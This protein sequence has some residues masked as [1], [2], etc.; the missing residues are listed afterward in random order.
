MW[1]EPLPTVTKSASHLRSWTILALIRGWIFHDRGPDQFHDQLG[2]PSRTGFGQG[3]HR[4]RSGRRMSRM[5]TDDT[6]ND[7]SVT[8][9]A[10]GAVSTEMS[11][12]ATL[13]PANRVT[14][15]MPQLSTVAIRAS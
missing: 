1:T 3:D 7:A 15:S 6:A 2:P 4:L 9:N 11:C 12:P 14:C 5:L 8:S 13:G 10:R